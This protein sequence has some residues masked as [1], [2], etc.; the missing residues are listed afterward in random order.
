MQWTRYS[1]W[2]RKWC[3]HNHLSWY[4]YFN[5]LDFAH[6]SFMQQFVTLTS[7][8]DDSW[9]NDYLAHSLPTGIQYL[10]HYKSIFLFHEKLGMKSMG[11]FFPSVL[12]IISHW[13]CR[14]CVGDL[15]VKKTKPRSLFSAPHKQRSFYDSFLEFSME[16][17]CG[18]ICLHMW[19]QLK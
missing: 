16:D 8:R 17:S 2:M 3:K 10:Y 18:L 12:T 6:L 5:G 7:M 14:A 1:F 9:C 13:C 15:N 19:T 11:L 4:L